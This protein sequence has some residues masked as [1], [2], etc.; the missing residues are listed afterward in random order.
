MKRYSSRQL[1]VIA[2]EI[3]ITPLLDLM[4]VLL[5][6]VIVLVPALRS[7]SRVFKEAEVGQPTKT[8]ELVVSPDLKLTLAGEAITDREL[9]A[10]LKTRVAVAPEVG[11]VVR[12]PTTLQ[13]S[14]LLEIM[15]ALRAASVRHTAVLSERPAKSP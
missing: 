3:Q 9:I 7:E 6:A 8:I 14:A 15:D 1:P 11:V 4:L 10:A 2:A 5:L 13:A 12:I